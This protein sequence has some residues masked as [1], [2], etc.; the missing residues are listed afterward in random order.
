MEDGLFPSTYKVDYALA[1]TPLVSILIPNKDHTEDLDKALRS[2]FEKTDYPAYEV[3]V[4]ENNSTLPQTFAYYERIAQ[5]AAYSR[6]RVVRYKGG[7]NFSA[8][9][10]FRP[11]SGKG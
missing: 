10:N 6:C 4:I 1:R 7:F 3:I 11:E 5:D 8:I 2:I 9:N